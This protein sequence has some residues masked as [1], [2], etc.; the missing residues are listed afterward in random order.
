MAWKIVFALPLAA[1]LIAQSG[2]TYKARLAAVAADARTRPQLAGLGSASAVLSGSKLTITGSFDGLLSPATVAQLRAG[3]AA[4]VRGP[5]VQELTISKAVSGTISG[6][7]DLTPQQIETLQKGG[8]YVQISSEKAPEGV[9]W[10][11]L[12]R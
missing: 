1:V 11:W 6:S 8:F 7:A 12:L 3:V 2:E 10:G 4:G 5:V 9:L